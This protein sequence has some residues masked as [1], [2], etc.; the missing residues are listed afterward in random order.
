LT[1]LSILVVSS[2]FLAGCVP[3]ATPEPT[4]EIVEETEEPIETEEPEIELEDLVVGLMTDKSGA[5]AIYGPSQTQGFYLGLEYAT[6]GTMEVAGR[7][8]VVIICGGNV[9]QAV[10]DAIAGPGG[11]P[12]AE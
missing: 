6:N 12:V 5:L 8:I 1:L 7:K 4:E 11:L 3:A 2:L 10:I 9:S